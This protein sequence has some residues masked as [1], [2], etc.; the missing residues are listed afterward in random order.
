MICKNVRTWE[1]ATLSQAEGNSGL[2]L[3]GKLIVEQGVLEKRI[4]RVCDELAKRA[5]VFAA[6]ANLLITKPEHLVFKGQAVA[7][8]FAGESA[9]D[10]DAMAV[11]LLLADLRD[12]IAKKNECAKSLAE[13]GIDSRE[14]EEERNQRLSRALRPPAKALDPKSR[15]KSGFGFYPNSGMGSGRP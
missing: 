13:L 4:G 7:E 8:E 1:A 10:R 15:G 12:A 6:V 5:A 11:D 2:L 14:T 3:I 9:V